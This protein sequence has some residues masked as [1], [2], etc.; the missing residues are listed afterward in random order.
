MRSGRVTSWFK[1]RPDVE[2]LRAAAIVAVLLYHAGVPVVSGGYVGVDVFFVISGFLITRLLISELERSGAV[3]VAR[4]YA[5][6][7][8]RLLPAVACVLVVVAV[9]T[10]LLL[11]PAQRATVARDLVAAGVYIVNW[12][13]SAQAVNYFDIGWQASPVQHFWSLAVEEQFYLVW[14]ALLL[15]VAWWVRRRGRGMRSPFAVAVGAVA[16]ASLAYSAYLTF[17]QADTAY[18]ST[19][20]RGWEFAVGGGLAIVPA[21]VWPRLPRRAAAATAWAGIGALAWATLRFDDQTLFPGAAA[22]VPTLGA[23]AIIAAGSASGPSAASRDPA[24]A[25]SPLP[26]PTRAL[27]LRPVRYVGRISYAWYL[28][29]WP[30]LIFAASTL[31]G[32]SSWQGLMVVAVSGVAAVATHHLIEEPFR[33][34]RNFVHY[35]RRALALGATCT[36]V[37]VLPGLLLPVTVQPV[38]MKPVGNVTGA[39]ALRRG[40]STQSSIDAVHPAPHKAGKDWP[41]AYTDGCH[42]RRLGVKSPKCVYGDPSSDTTVVLFGDSH[43]LMYFPPLNALAKKRHWRLV[44]LTKSGCPPPETTLYNT[45]LKRRYGECDKWREHALHRMEDMH[46]DMIVM[47]G[48]ATYSVVDGGKRVHQRASAQALARGYV[49]ALHD[50]RDTGAHLVVIRDDPHPDKNVPNCVSRWP[51][52]LG[53]CATPR[54][55]ALSYTPVGARAA[56]RVKGVDLLDPTRV[57][58]RDKTCPGVI[59]D[60][61]VYMVEDHLT[62]TYARTLAPWLG[63]KLPMKS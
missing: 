31:N 37:A 47:T 46:P 60:A 51:R 23:A 14:P 5:R 11:P 16:A 45:G 9:L 7:A 49:A 33:R 26:A 44:S 56:A 62:A 15:G 20:A 30:L 41:R 34:A 48:R 4:F 59:G 35:P 61:L 38:P 32:L 24:A 18:F 55:E 1:F 52:H 63:R 57:L 39:P 40:H 21:R 25:A 58:C 3:S 36:A 6:R 54:S 2:G 10:G 43:A 28:W 22:L 17:T 29:H 13:L 12:K 8:K 27:T 19:L 53:K 42:V 50:L